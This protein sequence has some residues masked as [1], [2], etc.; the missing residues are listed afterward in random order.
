MID[1]IGIAVKDLNEGIAKY[2]G[3]LGLKCTG[4]EEIAEQKVKV[5]MIPVGN[6]NLELLESTSPDGP[7]A[8]F[9][10]RK[11]EGFHHIAYKVRDIR[12]EIERLK[13]RGVRLID[14]EPRIGAHG[15]LIAFLHP[16][17]T[18]GVLMELV[19]RG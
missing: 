3:I 15:A 6:V 13:E 7:V 10:E 1:H 9:L 18:G 2:E 17:S 5:A 4:T 14:Q 11:G 8:R 12:G 16:K 19:E